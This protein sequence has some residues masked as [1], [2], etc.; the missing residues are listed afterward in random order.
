MLL[1]NMISSKKEIKP[2]T[3]VLLKKS[4]K[5][6]Y[7]PSPNPEMNKYCGIIAV[8]IEKNYRVER[9]RAVFSIKQPENEKYTWHFSDD[10][11]ERIITETN[12]EKINLL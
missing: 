2:G 8:V 6:D 7:F 3:K 10:Y 5:N 12:R 11:V 4:F 9:G 1:T